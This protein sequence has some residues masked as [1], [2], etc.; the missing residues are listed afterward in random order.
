[1]PRPIVRYGDHPS[2]HVEYWLPPV[3]QVVGVA[4]VIHGGWWRARHGLH[5]MNRLCADLAGRGFLAW[6]LE[7]RRIDG[8]GGGWPQTLDDVADGIR[9]LNQV[10]VSLDGT[11]LVAIGHSAGGHLALLAA[12]QDL[13]HAVIGLAPITD[14]ARCYEEELGEGAVS[15]FM[16]TGPGQDPAGYRAASPLCRLPIGRPQLIVH[17][18]ADVRVPIEHSRAYVSAAKTQG[19]DIELMELAEVDHF[20]VIDPDEPGWQRTSQWLET[21]LES[22]RTPSGT[23]PTSR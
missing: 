23:D 13:V 1:M 15:P 18:D 4:V 17:G 2:Q 12:A 5:L 22:W 19:D 7:Y 6:N 11:P 3:E 9:A 16:G 21:R 10:P 8:D 20:H 14:L